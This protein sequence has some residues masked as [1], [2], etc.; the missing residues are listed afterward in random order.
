MKRK[1]LL[2]AALL[3]ISGTMVAGWQPDPAAAQSAPDDDDADP[4]NDPDDD[5]DVPDPDDADTPDPVD[6]PEGGG[7]VPDAGG[8]VPD[9]GGDA[10]DGG[11]DVPE[12]GGDT[13]DGGS[14]APDAD[15]DAPGGDAD[16]PDGDGGDADGGA[17]GGS[18]G[19][20]TAGDDGEGETDGDDD[21]GPAAPG[22]GDDDGDDD[23]AAP[24]GGGTTGDDDDGPD[25]DDAPAPGAAAAAD[26]DDDDAAAPAAGGGGDDDDGPNDD[27]GGEITPGP[28]GDSGDDDDEVLNIIGGGDE[29]ESERIRLDEADNIESDREGYRYRKHEFVALDLDPAELN[30]LRADGFQVLQSERLTALSGTVY[31]LRG[32]SGRS[33]DDMLSALEGAVDPGTLSL[34][35]L[36]DSS[37]ARIRTGTKKASVTRTAC[38][39]RIGLIDTGVAANLGM[40]KHVQVEQ[41]AFNGPA[42]APRLHGTAVAHLFAGTT[43]KAGQRTRI[44]VADVFAG[45][46]ATSGSTY[47][48]VKALDWMAAQ[49]V[50]VINVS[51]AGPRNPV[52][53]S[54]VER[55]VGKGHIIVAAAGNDGP[56]APPVFPGCLQRCRR[57]DRSR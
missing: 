25:D 47:A 20:G 39:C 33:D 52:V 34:N 5:S 22:G 32:P 9:G 24:A 21:A 44:L 42:A 46:R 56:V 6:V 26:D 27:D 1:I 45:P 35:H 13:P 12:S 2:P 41:R 40:F 31:L 7:D 3:A 30:R 14:D 28:G 49:G 53:A 36:F 29:T 11:G 48:L 18:E 37:S 8:D 57:R 43:A 55:L 50:P 23:D 51:L 10:P 15:G 19:G 17:D 54:T 38:G 4:D 16:A